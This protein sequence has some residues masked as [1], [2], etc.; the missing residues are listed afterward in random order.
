MSD[1]LSENSPLASDTDALHFRLS[2][3]S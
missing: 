3:D 2:G 1:G